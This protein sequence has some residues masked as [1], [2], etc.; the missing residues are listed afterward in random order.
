MRHANPRIALLAM[1]FAALPVQA[2]TLV[3]RNGTEISGTLLGATARQID[4]LPVSGKSMKVPLNTVEAIN[5]SEPPVVAPSPPLKPAPAAA[6]RRAVTL[7]AGTAFRVR[8][9]GAID[10]DH[11]QAGAKFRA[12]IDDPIMLGGDVIVPRGADV[13]MVAAKVEQG[14]KMKGSDLIE[15][16][17]NSVT[18][19]G[20]SYPVATS[21]SETKSAGEGKKTAGKIVGGAGLGAI[22]GGIAGG[23]KGAGIG[24]LVGGAGGTVL[25]ATSQPHLKIPA[26]SRLQFQLTSDWKVQ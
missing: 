4:F 1:G 14:G 11:T 22:I 8:T 23:G 13:T 25:A 16:K 15:L 9:I 18:V 7:P 26:E 12:A 24:A 20:R 21:V 5:F 3:L 6:V 2:D 17:V 10:V 19:G